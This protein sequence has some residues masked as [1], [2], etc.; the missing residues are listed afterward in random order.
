[1]K[2]RVSA[3]FIGGIIAGIAMNIVDYISY[4]VGDREHLYDWAAIV[5]FGKLPASFGEII[6]AQISQLFFAGLLGILFSYFLLR[7]TSV[8]YLLKG[9]I[10]G[11]AAWFFIYALAIIFRLPDLETHSLG[12][13][14]SHF[15]SA[16]I[17]GLALGETLHR[18]NNNVKS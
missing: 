5:I 18:I 12:S 2:D 6:F 10:Y 3:G 1:L 7:L 4:Y 15:I 13:V 16:S 14:V 8:N 11:L 17:Y 9:W